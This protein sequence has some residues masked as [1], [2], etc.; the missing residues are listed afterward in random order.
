MIGVEIAILV[1]VLYL[2]VHA[3]NDNREKIRR[4]VCYLQGEMTQLR[5]EMSQLRGEMSGLKNVPRFKS[6]RPF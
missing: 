2:V 1:G 5:S 6:T 4:D 3:L